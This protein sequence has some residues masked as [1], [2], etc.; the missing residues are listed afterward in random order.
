MP[1]KYTI[2]REWRIVNN[3]LLWFGLRSGVTSERKF[4]DVKLQEPVN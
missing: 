2:E 3:I 4:W 1:G